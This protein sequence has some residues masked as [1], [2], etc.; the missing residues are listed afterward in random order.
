M[1]KSFSVAQKIGLSLMILIMGYFIST[2]VS[3]TLGQKTE[4]RLYGI[5]EYLFTASTQSKIALSVFEEQ[6]KYYNDV[7]MVGNMGNYME[8]AQKKADEVQNALETIL[9]LTG[10]SEK[11]IKNI[12]NTSEE[13]KRFNADAQA[14]YMN[15]LKKSADSEDI[16]ESED[17]E[18]ESLEDEIFRIGQQT[19]EFRDRLTAF[20]Q[21]FSD[22]LKTELADISSLIRRYRYVNVMIFF[23]IAGFVGIAVWMIISR[24]VTRP[25]SRIIENLS[26]FSAEIVSE[27]LQ[28]SCVSRSLADRS[29]QQAATV[30]EIS[31]S[32][33]E[34]SSMTKRNA[35][36]AAEAKDIVEKLIVLVRKTD[37]F[38]TELMTSM[39]DISKSSEETF[40][41][42]KTIDEIAFQTNL[43][44][45]NA[46]VEAARA[47][48]AGAGFAVVA[49]EV[50]NLALRSAKAAKTTSALIEETVNKIK[51]GSKITSD[52]IEAFKALAQDAVSMKELMAEIAAASD[53]Q[54]QGTEHVNIGI[55]QMDQITQQNAATAEQAASYSLEMNVRAEQMKHMVDELTSLVGGR[56]FSASH[57]SPKN[58]RPLYLIKENNL[59]K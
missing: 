48:Q 32:L 46:A 35:Y 47:G 54:A 56:S 58:I 34:M 7:I 52:T 27:A 38:M 25:L 30:E 22:D 1:R 39:S 21:D 45:L 6:I 13:L 16:F 51:D 26:G 33:E 17:E 28:R 19:S 5:S 12:R 49:D 18:K 57:N 9:A 29:S 15:Y 41:I 50:R 20:S 55:S 8:L 23:I 10:I 3:F 37:V 4:S 14:V 11:K 36:S 59:K 24:S 43:L 2:G 42:I 53:N 44:A 40:K 31:S